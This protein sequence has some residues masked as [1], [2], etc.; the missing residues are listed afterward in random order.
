MFEGTEK[1]IAWAKDIKENW[2]NE[3]AILKAIAERENTV[4]TVSSTDPLT[5]QTSTHEQ[6][7]FPM[8]EIEKR[9]IERVRKSF[10][11]IKFVS[12]SGEDKKNLNIL[13]DTL[14]E[15]LV[16]NEES[17]FWIERKL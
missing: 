2:L 13:I 10:T 6:T 14:A 4:T 15:L 17:I 8:E 11:G 9:A 12:V 1:Q 7:S 3:L 16:T 5:G